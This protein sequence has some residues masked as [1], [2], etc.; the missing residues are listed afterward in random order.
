MK[1][2]GDIYVLFWNN[3]HSMEAVKD[4]KKKVRNGTDCI[5]YEQGRSFPLFLLQT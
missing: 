3:I 5:I 1:F 2:L 4:G